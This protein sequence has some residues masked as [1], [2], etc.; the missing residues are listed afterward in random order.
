MAIINQENLNSLM[1]H[2]NNANSEFTTGMESATKNFAEK[3]A[4]IWESEKAVKFASNLKTA[5][6][7]VVKQ[8]VDAI[9]ATYSTLATNVSNHNKKNDGNVRTAALELRTANVS[10]ITEKIKSK[11][12]NGDEGLIEGHKAEEVLTYY[13]SSTD[14]I[15]EAMSNAEGS[16]S[17]SRAFGEEEMAS[18]SATLKKLFN[19]WKE[20]EEKLYSELKTALQTVDTDE[21]SMAST[22]KSNWGN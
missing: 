21:S 10:V 12:T 14:K 3:T 15:R 9:N 20:T 19:N 16:I 1:K 11:F 18:L 7:S 6:D 2:I 13:K 5:L 22:N 4:E 17:K 8:Y